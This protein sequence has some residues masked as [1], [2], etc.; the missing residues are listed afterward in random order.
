MRNVD[1]QSGSGRIIILE[2]I[3]Q[4]KTQLYLKSFGSGRNSDKVRFARAQSE[5]CQAVRVAQNT[6]FTSKAK[7]VE[8]GRIGGKVW[9]CIRDMQY[10]RRR[11]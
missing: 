7:E 8:K 3:F 1:T 9:K 11:L 6:W 4:K 10:G 5:A 2:P